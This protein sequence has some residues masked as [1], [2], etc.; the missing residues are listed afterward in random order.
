MPTPEVIPIN[1]SSSR[2]SSSSDSR[3]LFIADDLPEISPTD[4][5]LLDEETPVDQISMPTA[6]VS[7]HDYT[8]AFAQLRATVDQIFIEQ[9]ETRFHLDEL[10]VTFSK[11]ISNIEIAFLT[12]SY[13]Q[14]RVILAQTNVLCKEMQAQKDALSKELDAMRKE[15]NFQTLSAHLA[16]II[17]YMIRGRDDKKGEGSSSRGTQ[18]PNNQSRP[19]DSGR[20]RGSRS[21]PSR[22][23][24][25]STSSRGFRYWL[26][27]S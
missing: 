18:P 6:I 26:G 10:K 7:S 27:G 5:V 15:E 12:A 11:R 24:G 17:A 3:M 19:G 22:K 13:N 21:E 8:D 14:D 16:E 23:R 9:V 1:P 4:D 25:G 2:S 20:G